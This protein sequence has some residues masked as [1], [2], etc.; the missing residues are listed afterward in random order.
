MTDTIKK[1]TPR[2]EYVLVLA[3]GEPDRVRE[4]GLVTP[5]SVE[6][7]AK[8]FGTIEAVGKKAQEIDPELKAGRRVIFG[9]F[10]GE[11]IETEQDGK[12]VEYR[13]LHEEDVIAFLE[14]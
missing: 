5:D 6:E 3:D 12:T 2:R 9:K 1:V 13:L 10:A 7:E 4:S 14:D 8:A 11:V